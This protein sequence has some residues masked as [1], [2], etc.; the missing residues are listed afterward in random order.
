MLFY[1]KIFVLSIALV[2][3]H[4][5]CTHTQAFTTTLPNHGSRISRH[6]QIP[7]SS[8]YSA[9]FSSS[10]ANFNTSTNVNVGAGAGANANV[11]GSAGS[12]GDAAAVPPAQLP[13]PTN[14]R[15]AEVLGLRLMQEGQFEQALTGTLLISLWWWLWWWLLL[16]IC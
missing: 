12:D 13:Q 6:C 3:L 15:E 2:V 7:S 9:R 14:F 16:F 5:A 11:N 1:R 8:S 10:N 4:N